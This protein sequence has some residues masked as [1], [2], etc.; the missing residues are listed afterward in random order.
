[1]QILIKQ[2][3]GNRDRYSL[4]SKANLAILREYYKQYRPKNWLFP[5]HDPS[6]PINPRT[7]TILFRDAKRKA[8]IK[9][10]V[11]FHSLRHSF[12]THLLEDNVHICHIQKL[13]GHKSIHT[14]CIY[15]HITRLSLLNVKSPMDTMVGLGNG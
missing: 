12:A 10:D 14:T 8:G 7:L 11:T 15:L 5:G 1:M 4:L 6:K 9:K 13:L 2:G 3:K